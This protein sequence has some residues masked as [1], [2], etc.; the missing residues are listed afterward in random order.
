MKDDQIRRKFRNVLNVQ[1]RRNGGKEKL[2][3]HSPD[4]Y[5]AASPIIQSISSEMNIETDDLPYSLSDD[6]IVGCNN[7]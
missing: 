4:F 6:T 5:S 1:Q 2:H 7:G 3:Q